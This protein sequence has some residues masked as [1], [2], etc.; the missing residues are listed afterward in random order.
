LKPSKQ[1]HQT[2]LGMGS[3]SGPQ[4]IIVPPRPQSIRRPVNPSGF[5]CV[6]NRRGQTRTDE[7]RR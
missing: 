3:T 1:L 2:G 4:K 5:I 6:T 7:D